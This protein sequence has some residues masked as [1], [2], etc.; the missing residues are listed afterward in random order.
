MNMNKAMQFLL[1]GLLMT[2]MLFAVSAVAQDTHYRP[3]PGSE[4]QQ[5]ARH[6]QHSRRQKRPDAV[7]RLC[8][9]RH[10]GSALASCGFRWPDISAGQTEEESLH[11]R[12]VPEGDCSSRIRE[13]RF[14]SDHLV[15]M[16]RGKSGR[17]K[18]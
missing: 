7:R 15:R 13:E 11:R 14:Q 17:G 10:T 3:V 4:G 16:G 9:A 1:R 12:Q 18:L 8:R 6:S 5:G 2:T